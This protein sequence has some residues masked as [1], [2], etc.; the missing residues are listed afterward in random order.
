MRPVK[1][2]IIILNR[3]NLAY[4]PAKGFDYAIRMTWVLAPFH[5][6]KFETF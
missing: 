3:A 2:L 5:C 1:T 6:G 4:A